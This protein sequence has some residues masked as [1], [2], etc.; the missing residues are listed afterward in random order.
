MN[1]GIRAQN[2]IFIHET[3]IFLRG[4]EIHPPKTILYNVVLYYG[5]AA[6]SQTESKLY[7]KV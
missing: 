5:R 4:A 3:D 6:R 1:Y 7:S 2:S